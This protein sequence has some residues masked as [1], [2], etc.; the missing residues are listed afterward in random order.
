MSILVIAGLNTTAI[1]EIT[2][3]ISIEIQISNIH[4]R[5]EIF[6]HWIVLI[7]AN[8]GKFRTTQ[9]YSN[10]PYHYSPRF[11]ILSEIYFWSYGGLRLSRGTIFYNWGHE[12]QNSSYLKKEKILCS[13][14]I[15]FIGKAAPKKKLQSEIKNY[16]A[17]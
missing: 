13:P 15:N 2:R 16:H 9:Y 17:L 5:L 3:D 6:V 14:S 12:F 4:F 7:C 8:I 10:I 11:I 1:F